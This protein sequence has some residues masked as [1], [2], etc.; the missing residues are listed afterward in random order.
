M[1]ETRPITFAGDGYG[2]SLSVTVRDR[3]HDQIWQLG[4]LLKKREEVE[5]AGGTVL[6]FCVVDVT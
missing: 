2:E 6:M 4:E 3:V 5:D 1:F